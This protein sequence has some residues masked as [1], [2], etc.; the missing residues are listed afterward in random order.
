[1][2]PH[3][4]RLIEA[5][6]KDKLLE[7]PDRVQSDLEALAIYCPH[8]ASYLALLKFYRLRNAPGMAILQ[9]AVRY[10]EVSHRADNPL[11]Q[12]VIREHY[13]PDRIHPSERIP[14]LAAFARTVWSSAQDRDP[15]VG[16][17]IV[18][19]ALAERQKD[20]ALNVIRQILVIADEKPEV[21]VA[22]INRLIRAREYNMARSLIQEHSA[23]LAEDA[24]FQVARASLVVATED[25]EA[26][27]NL[28]ESPAFRPASILAKAQLVYIRLLQL[29]GRKGELEAALQNAL[30]RSL[31]SKNLHDLRLTG[32][33][34]AEL[35]QFDI[36]RKKIEESLP[37]TH[38]RRILET[39]SRPSQ[40]S[41]FESV[42]DEIE[43]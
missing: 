37:K 36:F 27:R 20:T 29:A 39:L 16:L 13:R 42:E 33:V 30:D 18:D 7:N 15:E 19:Q 43:F 25:M 12:A 32:S 28:L 9:T 8:P 17:R 23:K 5:A 34:F 24:D 4:D 41:L 3:L 10:W 26:A 31:A 40:R 11:L 21:A 2:E 1:V 22:C 35:G 38:A 6:T 14:Q